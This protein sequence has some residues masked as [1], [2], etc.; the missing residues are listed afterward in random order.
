M[1]NIIVKELSDSIQKYLYSNYA[2]E[3]EDARPK[4]LY[5]ALT[6]ALMEIIGK[7]W[8]NTKKFKSDENIYILSFEYMPGKLLELYLHKLDIIEEAK[9]SISKADVELKE[10]LDIEKEPALGFG[11][12]GVGSS[13]MLEALT[14]EKIKTV[15]YAMKYENG[16]MI[17]KIIDNEQVEYPNLWGNKKILWQ[18]KKG[19]NYYHDIF[20]RKVKAEVFDLPVLN[21]KKDFV[22]TLRMFSAKYLDLK[23]TLKDKIDYKNRFKDISLTEFLYVNIGED[24]KKYRLAQEYF[25]ACNCIEDIFRRHFK[26]RNKIEDFK[27]KNKIIVNE[28]HPTLSLIEFI[29]VLKTGY[30]YSIENSVDLAK[31]VF[32]HFSFQVSEDSYETY[33]IEMIKE[34][35]ERLY[36]TIIE[37][38][39]FLNKRQEAIIKEGNLIFRNVNLFLSRKYIFSSKIIR[40]YK[41]KNNKRKLDFSNIYRYK[42]IFF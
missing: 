15:A 1:N 22:N 40:D 38:N 12:L 2:K 37:L 3:I 41:Q 17:Q 26:Q 13:L 8:V 18:H 14:N 34:L 9:K 42:K 30:G 7:T 23:H 33:P 28:I 6:N 27:D 35:N 36:F 24:S 29:N 5:F 19:F 25:Y 39:E 11:E 31:E 32:Y 4:E 20:S 10:L 21:N 16:D